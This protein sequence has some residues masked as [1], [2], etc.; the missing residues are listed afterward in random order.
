MLWIGAGAGDKPVQVFNGASAA[1]DHFELGVKALEIEL[2]DDRIVALLDQELPGARLELFFKQL[3]LALREAESID[4]LG[5]V[6]VGK[7]SWSVSAQ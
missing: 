4:V 6:C 1:R 2:A 3:K 5:G 7:E